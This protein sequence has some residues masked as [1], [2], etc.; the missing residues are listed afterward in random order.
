ML[1]LSIGYELDMDASNPLQWSHAKLN[2]TL[3]KSYTPKLPWAMKAR[4]DGNLASEVFIYVDNGHII[5][6]SELVCW[7][8]ENIY[9]SICN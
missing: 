5:A 9:F 1:F 6:H 3:D 2:P 4:S 8:A 7:Q